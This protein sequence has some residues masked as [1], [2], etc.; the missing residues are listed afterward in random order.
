MHCSSDAHVSD[1]GPFGLLCLVE[2]H[3]VRVLD[4]EIIARRVQSQ[5][6]LLQAVL[7]AIFQMALSS[8]C[9]ASTELEPGPVVSF[10]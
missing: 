6:C 1:L 7:S 3:D 5:L 8:D 4:P 2:V 9:A 10:T